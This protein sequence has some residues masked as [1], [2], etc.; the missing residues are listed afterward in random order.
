MATMIYGDY[1]QLSEVI[2]EVNDFL[3]TSAKP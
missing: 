2:E 1:P 3:A